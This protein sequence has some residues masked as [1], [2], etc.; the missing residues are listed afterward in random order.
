MS[1]AAVESGSWGFAA[2]GTGHICN[3]LATTGNCNGSVDKAS[4]IETGGG[5]WPNVKSMR[6]DGA[7]GLL[8][9]MSS[10]QRSA[11]MKSISPLGNRSNSGLA[12]SPDMDSFTVSTTHVAVSK[13]ASTQ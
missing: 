8:F 3:V 7:R 6:P 2:A 5:R 12:T 9:Q 10:K 1:F 4:S 13:S 11:I